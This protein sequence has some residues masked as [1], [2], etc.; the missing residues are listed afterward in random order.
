MDIAPV[1]GSA[2]NH[3]LEIEG[4]GLSLVNPVAEEVKPV[5]RLL[6]KVLSKALGEIR[7]V[8]V[9][10]KG[11]TLSVHYRLVAEDKTDEVKNIF[12]RVTA[13]ARSLGKIRTT[14]GKKVYE[15]RPPVAWD[16]GKAIKLL[17]DKYQRPRGEVLPIFLGDDLTD[18]D[19]FKVINDYGGLS[20]FVGEESG[21]TAARYFL[22]SPA[23]VEELLGL[24]L[25]PGKISQGVEPLAG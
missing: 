20:V 24:L 1:R 19:G 23:E 5:F 9:E 22:R 15:V 4:P 7:G 6:A 17:L 2:G 11:L 8:L 14:S 25:E 16:K 3:G 13:V 10:D 18:E 21:D 12:E